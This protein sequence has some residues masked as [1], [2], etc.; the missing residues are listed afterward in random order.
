MKTRSGRRVAAVFA[1]E[2]TE[3]TTTEETTHRGARA[4][5]QYT[6]AIINGERVLIAEQP[7]E[8]EKGL[9]LRIQ[10]DV[11]THPDCLVWRND[12]GRRW[13]IPQDA[14]CRCCGANM[15]RGE[16][17]R[18]AIQVPAGLGTGSADLVGLRRTLVTGDMVGTYVGRFMGLEVKTSTGRLSDEQRRWAA[19][20]QRYG[21]LAETVRST[22]DAARVLR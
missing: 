22:D 20:V 9:M 19:A 2:N 7:V 1:P 5:A 3:L 15:K 21:G 11:A 14:S 13:I 6:D 8:R 10:R 17:I 16:N 12:V 4:G 18:G